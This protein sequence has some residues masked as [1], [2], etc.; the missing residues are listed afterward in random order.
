MTK[1]ELKVFKKLVK[2]MNALTDCNDFTF[3]NCFGEYNKC[4]PVECFVTRFCK[5]VTE[6]L[7]RKK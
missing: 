4:P 5:Q 2:E 7:R 6:I 3:T 1:A